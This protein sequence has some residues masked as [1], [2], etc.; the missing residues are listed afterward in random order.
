MR[1][2]FWEI[3]WGKAQNLTFMN[4]PLFKKISAD[5]MNII[6]L[7]E[8]VTIYF[9]KSF[10]RCFHPY[11]LAFKMSFLHLLFVLKLSYL[12]ALCPVS[13]YDLGKLCV[14]RQGP[15]RDKMPYVSQQEVQLLQASLID[16]QG[17]RR[18]YLLSY[19]F[20]VTCWL[21]LYWNVGREKE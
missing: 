1:L 15:R 16:T 4:I 6:S 18:S 8:H 5:F 20:G 10:R 9:T 3:M 12:L 21:T 13:L 2:I 11:K 19:W 14:G 7:S 17:L